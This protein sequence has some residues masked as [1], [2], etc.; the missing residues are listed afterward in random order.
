MSHFGDLAKHCR[1]LAQTCRDEITL[2]LLLAMAD[3][4]EEEARSRDE[5]ETPPPVPIPPSTSA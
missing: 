3:D 5:T 1:E 4:F 2:K